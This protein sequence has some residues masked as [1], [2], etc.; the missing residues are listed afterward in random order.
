MQKIKDHIC[1]KI[2]TIAL[3]LVIL[4]PTAVKLTHVFQH[5]KHQFCIGV[6]KT[7]FHNLNVECEFYKF[8][9]NHPLTFSTVSFEA[10]PFENTFIP[11]K[12]QYRFTNHYQHLH[13]LL[14][15]PPQLV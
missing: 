9:V 7:H 13:F 8:K 10:I 14:R 4:T 6:Q 1:Y 2:L 3:V 5:H 12:S 15:G 11:I